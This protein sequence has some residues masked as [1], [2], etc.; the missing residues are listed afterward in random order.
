MNELNAAS[1]VPPEDAGAAK[2]TLTVSDSFEFAGVA[3]EEWDGLVQDIGGDIYVTYDWLRI[4]WRHYGENRRL[5]LFVFRKERRLVGL[6]PMFIERIA[7]GP[8]SLKIAKRV[9]ADFALTIFALPLAPDY[10]EVIYAEL[11]KRL[12][13]GENCDAVWFGFMPGDDPT[14]NGLREACRGLRT[15][16]TV[17]RDSA[18]GPHTLFH[19]PDTFAS[20]VASLDGGDRQNY[21]RRL[22]LLDKDY[23]VE[24]DVVCDPLNAVEVL[25][26]FKSAHDRQWQAEGK[27][28]HFGDWPR[29]ELFN[30]DLV[31][32]LSRL[33]RVRLL[34]LSADGRVVACEYAFVFGNCCYW[35]LGARATGREWDR[36]GLGIL[37]LMQ[38]IEAMI[39]EGV[40][41]IEAGVGHYDYKVRFG[42]Q[43]LEIRSVLV[44]S[45]RHGAVLRAKLF[46]KLSDL[47]H[48]VY[49]R[50]WLKRL[51]P[52][53]RLSR[54]P[55]WRTWIRSRL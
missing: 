24:S 48:L 43:E 44:V 12:I 9:G 17:G 27:F 11:V 14:V 33:G 26:D 7:F 4:W 28:G 53:L 41:R 20:Y 55:F 3:R 35:R 19:L 37:G 49:Y 45:N 25:A 5:R 32:E 8:V 42:G 21:R 18:A 40:H 31:T 22:K 23:K 51:A 10:V 39:D 50:I 1:P 15:L 38:L 6:A 36:F 52:R 34:R 29:S 46:V 54:R 47:L 16:A 30:I 2:F 13:E